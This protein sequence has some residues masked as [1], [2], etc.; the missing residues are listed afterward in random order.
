MG[1]NIVILILLALLLGAAVWQS[2]YIDS[3]TGV[4][5][6]LLEQVVDALD[7]N[8][9]EKAAQAAHDFDAAWERQKFTY[10]ALF[11][12]KEVDIISASC[13]KLPSLCT[14]GCI[15]EALAATKKILFYVEHIRDIDGVSWENVL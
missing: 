11:E 5:A 8:D 13:K 9:T 6:D 4:L 3:S 10:E 7:H 2:A 15:P 12:H 1:K 14:P